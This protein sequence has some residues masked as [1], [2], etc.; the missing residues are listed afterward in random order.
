MC[1]PVK[2]GAEAHRSRDPPI[3]PPWSV[4]LFFSV[5]VYVPA[6]AVQP[7]LL[8]TLIVLGGDDHDQTWS[9]RPLRTHVIFFCV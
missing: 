1:G 3:A 5:Q 7:G 8:L 9:C 4:L 2:F 6:V